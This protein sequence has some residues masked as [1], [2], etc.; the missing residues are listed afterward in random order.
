M[1]NKYF[2]P[3]IEDIRVGYEF[4]EASEGRP[5]YPE[6]VKGRIEDFEE[7]Q[8]IIEE[9]LP[10][11]SIR[12]PYLTK[13]QIEAEGWKN[14]GGGLSENFFYCSEGEE[15]ESYKKQKLHYDLVEKYLIFGSHITYRKDGYDLDFYFQP[16][17]P[18]K[19]WIE[20]K[21]HELRHIIYMGE[22]KD[23]NTFRYI[24]KLLGV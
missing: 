19:H 13:E 9:K 17:C 23:I 14:I 3:N 6:W 7:A 8:L 5:G 10:R 12:V 4:E 2:T 21:I 11:Q 18:K 22:C 16:Y 15:S 24:C 1:E 20:I